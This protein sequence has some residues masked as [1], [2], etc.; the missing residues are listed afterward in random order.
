MTQKI[1]TAILFL[2]IVLTAYLNLHAQSIGE[3]SVYSS[4][5]TINDI[6]FD[7]NGTHYVLTQGGLFI[8][9]NN[10]ILER[11][12]T[13][14]G[15]HRL[16]GVR[17]V[18]DDLTEQ[19]IIAYPDGVID[20]LDVNTSE[21][22]QINDIE[23]IT[24]FSSKG[25]NDLTIVNSEV[26]VATEFGIITFDRNQFFVT[27]SYL[28]LGEFERGISVNA[29]SFSEDSIFAATANG[30]ATGALNSNLVNSN[31]WETTDITTTDNDEVI[32]IESTKSGLYLIA[33][34]S[35]YY[36]SSNNWMNLSNLPI[37]R[38]EYLQ[39]IGDDVLIANANRII[40]RAP[41]E[42]STI[43]YEPESKTIR[44]LTF[45]NNQIYIGTSEN[46]VIQIDEATKEEIILNP[47]GP[48]LNFF[49]KLAIS[50]GVLLASSTDQFPQTDP[51]NAIRGYYIYENNSWKSFNRNTAF[52]LSEFKYSTAYSVD[53]T[54]EN[55]F[56]GSW[57]NGVVIHSRDDN[58]ITV[59]DSR[60]SGLSG[61]SANRDFIVI[62]GIDTDS[63]NNTWA[64]SFISNLPLNVYSNSTNEWTHFPSLPISSDELYFRLFID[65]NDKLWI[66]LIDI[67]NNGKG[68]LVVDT[69]SDPFNDSDDTFKK[70]TSNENI[71]NLPDD[72]VTAIA[73][74]KKGEV[75]IGTS[76]GIA[77]FIF[78]DFIVSSNNESEFT[79]QWL[80]NAD[81]SATSRF[82]LR[83]V[84]VST[85]AVNSANQKWIG[86]VNQGLWLLNEDG[87]EILAR[88]TTNNSPLISNNI[89]DIAINDETGEVFI[90]TDLGLISVIE[91]AKSAVTKMDELKVYPNP[92][93]YDIHDQMVIEALADESIIKIVGADGSI[94][95][96][97]ETQGGRAT[98]SGL[99]QYGNQLASGVYF[100]VAL[101]DDG[102]EKGIGKVVIIR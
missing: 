22:I 91:T 17:S 97:L 54:D 5:S 85:I 42:G 83:D 44:T 90:S 3:W 75:W 20:L 21:I 47:S 74:D 68:L 61:I 30:L 36:R 72:N 77:R 76:R 57:G 84:N 1:R 65:S 37:S 13:L 62:S 15:M 95:T 94:F 100:L 8:V 52:E 102:S 23:R 18:F 39:K 32:D 59:F 41:D 46:G 11:Y 56:V 73:E 79:A 26:F 9:E 10:L 25:I 29:I 101:S 88:Y 89:Q 86:S 24:E 98:W 43:I 50:N 35:V 82:L 40:K 51:F 55:Y 4:F 34:D 80:I 48:Y 27:N 64:I 93:V 60:N 92:F 58:S 19:L 99:D 81:T 6:S 7:S 38:P 53:I 63:K 78:P 45:N 31:N 96:E 87:S 28:N 71:G 14:D 70:L 2:V 33:D 49:N 69:G 16:D 67:Q 12:T 66:P